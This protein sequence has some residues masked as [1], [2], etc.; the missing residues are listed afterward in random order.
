[1]G[2]N[3]LSPPLQATLQ[4]SDGSAFNLTGATSVVFVMSQ[5]GAQLFSKPAVITNAVN[6]VVTYNWSS[7][8]TAYSGTCTAIFLVTIGESTLQTFPTTGSF[9]IYFNT[10]SVQGTYTGYSTIGDVQRELQNF[11][12]TGRSIPDINSVATYIEMSDDFIN[13]YS[14]HDWLLHSGTTEYYDGYGLGPR[15]GM[16]LVKNL[17]LVS[18]QT[19]Q[20]YD[21]STWQTG[22]QGKPLDVSP[23]QAYEVYL[24]QGRIQFYYL[25]I[26]GMN[27]YQV[28][29]TYGYSTVPPSVRRLSA[30]LTALKVIAVWTRSTLDNY[31]LGDLRVAYPKDG[32]FGVLW[33]K[34][35][36]EANRLMTQLSVRRSYI[37]YG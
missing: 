8:D 15:A 35:T 27:A 19:V 16:I 5:D 3:D 9:Q 33:E 37:G 18:V 36:S 26:S 1:M 29:Y 6:G 14:Q 10:D 20:W 34:L 11:T 23:A 30:V 24:T 25:A 21:G 7:G 4:N 17:P 31:S 28:T 32:E 12:F 13:G 22:A 2:M